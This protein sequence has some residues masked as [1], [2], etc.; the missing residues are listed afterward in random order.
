MFR[1]LSLAFC[2]FSLST[3]AQTLET[4][5]M[6]ALDSAGVSITSPEIEL[7]KLT[8]GRTFTIKVGRMVWVPVQNK[9]GKLKIKKARLV[10]IDGHQMLFRPKNKNFKEMTYL[11]TELDFIAFTSGGRVAVGLVANVVIIVGVTM[12]YVFMELATKSHGSSPSYSD[13]LIP[14]R[15]NLDLYPKGKWGLRIVDSGLRVADY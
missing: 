10:A 13:L 11:D 5:S 14:L 1:L 7:Y 4:H 15:K 12:V 6:P 8:S 9:K 3:F 2:V